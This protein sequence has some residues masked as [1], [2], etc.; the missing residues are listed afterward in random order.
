MTKKSSEEKT[1]S[2]TEQGREAC[3]R[4]EEKSKREKKGTSNGKGPAEKRKKCKRLA[5][6]KSKDDETQDLS[7]RE[8]RRTTQ[9]IELRMALLYFKRTGS[10]PNKEGLLSA[11]AIAWR[12]F[13]WGG[14]GGKK[15]SQYALVSGSFLRS[16]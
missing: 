11:T 1:G 14:N 9:G 7:G 12:S 2:D 13:F 16:L 8:E 4:R 3:M 5:F 6:P 15:N 10:Q